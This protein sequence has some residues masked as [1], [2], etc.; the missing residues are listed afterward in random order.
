MAGNV[1]ILFIFICFSWL[2][3][4][5]FLKY[6]DYWPKEEEANIKMRIFEE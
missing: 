2:S 1:F 6:D 3:K 4:T 5:K